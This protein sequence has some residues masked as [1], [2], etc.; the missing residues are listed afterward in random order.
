MAVGLKDV[1][2]YIAPSLALAASGR[3]AFPP[4]SRK[5][6][7]T[8]SFPGIIERPLHANEFSIY[9]DNTDPIPLSALATFLSKLDKQATS[10][11]GMD[12]LFLQLSDFATGSNELRF[13]IIGPGRQSDR[14]AT[15]QGRLVTAAEG[16]T[17]ASKIA[18]GAGIVSAVAG[19]AA[20]AIAYGGANPATY[21][22][23]NHYHV[24]NIYVRAPEEPPHIV[25]R[26][27]VEH[28]RRVR[29]SKQKSLPIRRQLE[30]EALLSAVGSREVVDLAGWVY[31]SA[32]R[33]PY[34]RTMQGNQFPV[35]IKDAGRYLESPVAV[36]AIVKGS[37]DGLN[38]E[39]VHVLAELTDL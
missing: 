9:L 5:R 14:G 3:H 13:K 36:R 27:D 20:A 19:V 39:V 35:K 15:N 23:V 22:I 11:D 29:L 2:F 26:A 25:T 28:G 1:S 33:G 24:E 32:N 12:G 8:M 37:P 6:P 10:I 7:C 16:A 34:F 31:Y 17:T 21:R 4:S 30:S 18:A 38:L